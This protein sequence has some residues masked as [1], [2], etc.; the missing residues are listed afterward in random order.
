[1]QGG[2]VLEW[3]DGVDALKYARS[4][5]TKPEDL[6]QVAA[7]VFDV[8]AYVHYIRFVHADLK[9]ENI[10]VNPNTGDVKVID[11]GLALRLPA[12]RRNKGNVNVLAPELANL[13]PGQIHEGIDW[14]AYG[15]TLATLFA[16]KYLPA[17]TSLDL[18]HKDNRH[19][20]YVAFEIGKRG[21]YFTVEGVPD[22]FPAALRH[23]LYLCWDPNP[24]N[25][26]F[27]TDAK[28]NLLRR[29]P[30]FDTILW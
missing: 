14:W 15:S 17:Y 3:F 22:A 6:V 10:L 4:Q 16:Y 27:N 24:D 7:K 21:Q 19:M 20:R 2:L 12:N 28:L 13:V 11:F 8:L 5:K 23:L 29:M 1:M 9:P 26:Q 30:F 18:N 25:R